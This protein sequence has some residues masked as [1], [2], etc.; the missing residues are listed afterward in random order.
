MFSLCVYGIISILFNE[1]VNFI[2]ILTLY[3]VTWCL[4][5]AGGPTSEARGILNLSI[6]YW[7]SRGWAFVDVNYGGSTGLSSVPSNCIYA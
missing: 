1:R 2:C 4:N 6:Q 7:T 5:M 3:M